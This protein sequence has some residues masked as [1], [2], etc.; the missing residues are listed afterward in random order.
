MAWIVDD[1]SGII[2]HNG[3]TGNYNSYLGFRPETGTAV[4]V[5]SNLAPG[6]RIPA[7]VMG[8]KLLEELGNNSNLEVGKW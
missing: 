8:V 7:T 6:Y 2:W 1:K 4:V 5:L 3:G